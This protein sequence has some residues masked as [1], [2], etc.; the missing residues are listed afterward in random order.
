MNSTG[1]LWGW[2]I[3]SLFWLGALVVIIG[4][5]FL[6]VPGWVLTVGNK[7]NRWIST[8]VFFDSLDQP[9]Y[10]ERWIYRHHRL[11]GVI[12]IA[13]VSYVLYT[14]FVNIGIDESVRRIISLANTEF[15]RWLYEEL[16]YIFL[17]ASVIALIIGLII[18]IR[19]SLLKAIESRSN[20][21]FSVDKKLDILDKN[22]PMDALPGNPRLFGLA[23]IL[24]G[25]YI[26][27]STG[28]LL[29]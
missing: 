24:G 26:M 1:Y 17:G 22:I 21:W 27:I 13:V 11:S 18:F 9:R 20:H 3:A 6:C 5:T 2:L 15:S 8:Q 14:F 4:F 16:F 29:L 10:Q 12:I 7:L 25:I 19:P 23:V 28:L